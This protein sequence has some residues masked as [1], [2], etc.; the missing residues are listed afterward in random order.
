MMMHANDPVPDVR[1]LRP[2]TPDWL[3]DLVHGLLAKDPDDRPAGAAAV[4]AAL[5]AQRGGRRGRDDR[6]ARRRCRRRRSGSTPCRRRCPPPPPVQPLPPDGRP[7]R[8]RQRPRLGARP[9]GRGGP[10]RCSRG[11]SSTTARTPTDDPR[12]PHPRPRPPERRPA[13]RPRRRQPPTDPTRPTPTA[14]DRVADAHAAR[15]RRRRGLVAV[16]LLRRG[17]RARARRHSS[18]RTPRRRSTT[19]PGHREGPARGR[20]GE[21]RGGDRQA[22]RGVRQGGAGGRDPRRGGAAPRPPPPGPHRRRRRSTPADVR[23][24][25]GNVTFSAPRPSP[26][27]A[28]SRSCRRSS[29]RRPLVRALGT[30]PLVLTGRRHDGHP[31][32]HAVAAARRRGDCPSSGS[33]SCPAARPMPRVTAALHAAGWALHNLGSLPHISV[34]GA[35][36]TGTHG[37]GDANGSLVDRRRRRRARAR[38]RRAVRFAAGRPRVPRGRA[39]AGLPRRRDPALAAGRA[40]LRGAAGRA[41]GRADG[42]AARRHRASPGRRVQRQPLHAFRDPPTARRGVGQAARPRRATG[43]RRALLGVDAVDGGRSTRCPAWTRSPRP[44]SST[45][46]GPWHHR[47]PHFR[48]EFTPERGGA[49]CSRSTSCPASTPPRPWWP[50]DRAGSPARRPAAGVRGAHGR[51]RR[52]VAEPLPRPGH[53]DRALHVAPR[54]GRRRPGAAEVERALEPYDPRPH[55]GKVFH[56][57][58]PGRLGQMY[59]DLP[60]FRALVAACD[61]E[62]RFRNET[63]DPLLG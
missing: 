51:R 55:W 59:P 34:A 22:R 13:R 38:G 14:D 37:S 21:G 27:R 43:P 53:G 46:P 42:G 41:H 33:R 29:P 60:R 48:P 47:L 24:W 32:H 40:G 5:A 54:P 25:A 45:S 11:R 15:P 35:C 58:E 63:T 9:R 17:R 30:G 4:A 6:P 1:D 7:A 26:S 8:R 62:R 16:G 61:P 28:R 2:D 44:T 23:N 20:P 12:R 10:R 18:T 57:L 52:P 36:S 3:A 56:P 19:R 49:S 50:L 39:R 31:G